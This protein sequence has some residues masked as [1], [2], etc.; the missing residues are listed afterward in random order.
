ME[1]QIPSGPFAIVKDVCVKSPD[2]LT[3]AASGARNLK[4]TVRSECTSYPGNAGAPRPPRPAAAGCCC[5]NISELNP[6]AKVIARLIVGRFIVASPQ[7]LG[8]VATGTLTRSNRV[9]HARGGRNHKKHKTHKRDSVL[10]V[11]LLLVP[12]EWHHHCCATI[13]AMPSSAV[14][15]RF[16]KRHSLSLSAIAVTMLW[17]T[18]YWNADPKSHTGSFF[19]NA[20]ADW[21]GVVVT[22]IATKWFFEKDSKESR[23]PRPRYG[24]ALL[25]ALHEHSLT[26]FLI[27]T[28]I[29]WVILYS[30]VNPES[31]WGTVVSN[32]VSEWSQQLGLVLLTKKLIERGSKESHG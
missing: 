17:L 3:V 8:G 2:T 11:L 32:I 13:S 10:L 29:G 21:T 24:S 31:K 28:G 9:N 14:P 15:E 18:L 6:N 20:L 27:A 16:W 4:V 7:I 26:I 5:A 22:V 25:E 12:S 1:D 23:Q 19:G 30:R